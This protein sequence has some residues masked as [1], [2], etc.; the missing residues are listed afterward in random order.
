M[1]FSASRLLY[2]II[3]PMPTACGKAARVS[4]TGKLH[5]CRSQLCVGNGLPK[6]A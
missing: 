5:K 2:Y 4:Q 6:A 1:A 3:A